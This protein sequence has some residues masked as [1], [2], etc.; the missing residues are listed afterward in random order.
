[1]I[2]ISELSSHTDRYSTT[3]GESVTYRGNQD[4]RTSVKLRCLACVPIKFRSTRRFNSPYIQV[5]RL[6][7]LETIFRLITQY[8]EN[9]A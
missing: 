3:N 7:W 5:L 1:M 4:R 6:V 2:V 9:L 8:V